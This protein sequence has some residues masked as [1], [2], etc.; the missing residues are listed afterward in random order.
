MRDKISLKSWVNPLVFFSLEPIV[1][2]EAKNITPNEVLSDLCSCDE[3]PSIQQLKIRCDEIAIRTNSLAI[4]PAEKNIL[5]KLIWPL[6][7][8]RSSYIMGNYIGT[9]SL[10]GMMSEMSAIMFFDTSTRMLKDEQVKEFG[11]S[12]EK[13]GQ[14]QRI[15]VLVDK[16]IIDEEL[17]EKFTTVRKI[18]RKYLHLWSFDHGAIKRDSVEIFSVALEIASSLLGITF[19]NGESVL[20]PSVISYL[21]HKGL[22]N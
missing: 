10:A 3:D 5:S 21:K 14:E 13:M 11:R 6:R 7:N 8:A 1:Q 17:K 19:E 16:R 9:I 12:F 2:G 20:S 22:Y 15:A 18:R 4:I